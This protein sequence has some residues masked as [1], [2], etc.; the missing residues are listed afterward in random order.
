MRG[1]SVSYNKRR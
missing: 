1:K